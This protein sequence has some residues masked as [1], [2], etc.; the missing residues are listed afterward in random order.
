MNEEL[1]R[2]LFKALDIK[3]PEMR[4]DKWLNGCCPLAPVTHAKGYDTNP[5]F[6]VSV[7]EHH[8]EA[9]HFFCWSCG[10]RGAV[11]KLLF[12]MTDIAEE[13]PRIKLGLAYEVLQAEADGLEGYFPTDWAETKADKGF[14]EFPEWWLESF[15]PWSTSQACQDYLALRRVRPEAA[16]YF[17]LR[18]DAKMHAVGFPYW[19]KKGQLAGMRGRYLNPKGKNK[20]HDYSF[21]DFNNSAKVWFNE[22]RIDWLRPLVVCEGSF[23]VLAVHEHYTNVASPWTC[24]PKLEML[25]LL[26][27]CVSVVVAFDSDVAGQRGYQKI[28]EVIGNEIAV[29]QL[30]LPDGFDCAEMDPDSLRD[31]LAF[32]GVPL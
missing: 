6:G 21:N 17:E 27:K 10:E 18:Y 7:H 19:N 25:N 26:K 16:D 31:A 20:Y 8:P 15:P 22:S 4:Q 30:A 1:A 29:T 32:A 3:D 13:N 14:D 23:D 28:M 24:T 2:R 12:D 11:S 5:S 9:S